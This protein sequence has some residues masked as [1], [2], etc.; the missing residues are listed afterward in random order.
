[1][2]IRNDW[3]SDYHHFGNDYPNNILLEDA[4]RRY[5]TQKQ[6]L[7][8]KDAVIEGSTIERIV[9][10][11]HTN[12]LSPTVRYDKIIHFDIDSL[13][14]TG[15]TMEFDEK[16]WL[17]VNR[18]I[19][20]EVYK[21]SSI[22]ECDDVI[23]VIKDDIVYQVPRAVLSQVQFH[24]MG[25]TDNKYF[26]EVDST[27]IMMLPLNEITECV[28]RNDIYEL[29]PEDFYKVI[30]INRIIIPGLIVAKIEW[31]AQRQPP[32][33]PSPPPSDYQIT[34]SPTIRVNQTQKYQAVKYIDGDIDES[35]TFT[36]TIVAENV[37][38][39]AYELIVLND[40]ECEIRC[41]QSRYEIVLVAEDLSDGSIAEKNIS[42]INV[43]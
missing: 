38:E 23:S 12:P 10:Q 6:S 21:T 36:F 15:T 20:K 40:T 34:G 30:D 25:Y 37:P 42:L 5:E 33:P 24:S 11:P 19:N 16:L 41:N 3:M 2:K 39:S 35:A 8:G 28:K 4:Q 31:T 43:F 7:E 29:H 22:V 32:P 27:A 26:S 17:V 1:M 13:I 14:Q 9:V 18:V